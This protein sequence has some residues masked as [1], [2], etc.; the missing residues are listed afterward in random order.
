M[1]DTAIRH[2]AGLLIFPG[3][4]AL[5]L[6]G[7]WEVFLRLPGWAP[8]AIGLDDQ[9]V[10]ADGGLMITPQASIADCPPLDLLIIPGGGGVDALLDRPDVLDFVRSRAQA[11]EFGVASI[12]TGALVLGAAG[13]L[14]GRRAA[15]HWASRPLLAALGAEP[16]ADRVVIDGPVATGGGVT[17]GIDIAL[18]LAARIAGPEIAAAAE[19]AI[20]YA[21]EP[22]MGSGRPELAP[23]AVLTMVETAFAGRIAARRRLVDAAAARLA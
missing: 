23:P 6:I 22:P 1:T 19:L 17:A 21:P 8:V 2:R 16:S 13:L 18:A 12:C 3:L 4:T 15:T 10:A 14:R 7:P 5:D 11:A 20:E 9:P